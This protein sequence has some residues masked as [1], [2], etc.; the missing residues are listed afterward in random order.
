MLGLVFGSLLKQCN[1]RVAT[2]S[3]SFWGYLPSNLVSITQ[4]TLLLLDKYSIRLCVPSVLLISIARRPDSN[5]SKTT[6][7]LYTSHFSVKWPVHPQGFSATKLKMMSILKCK[8][9]EKKH[10]I[11]WTCSYVLWCSIAICTHNS[12]GHVSH[13]TSLPVF[14]QIDSGQLGIKLLHLRVWSPIM[15]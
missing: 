3:A 12:S 10:P 11:C 7:K 14:S 8:L 1:A 13:I 4:D 15:Q 6:P 5:S 9:V 2:I